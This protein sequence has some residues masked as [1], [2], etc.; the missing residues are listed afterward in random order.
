MFIGY[1]ATNK[2]KAH[3][4]RCSTQV[5][6]VLFHAY[7]MCFYASQLWH[8]FTLT[9]INHLRVAYNDVFRIL[10]GLPHYF[11]ASEIQVQY[12]IDTFFALL[13]KNTY[14]FIECCYSSA[15]VWQD[16]I[17]NVIR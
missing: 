1:V 9:A 15:N 16:S 11:S 17:F 7:C 5:K 6:N 10:H 13:R 2:L 8:N 14:N 4:S 12:G 3:F